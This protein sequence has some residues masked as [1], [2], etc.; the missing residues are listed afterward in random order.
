VH[1]GIQ[2][3]TSFNWPSNGFDDPTFGA[4]NYMYGTLLTSAIALLIGGFTSLG[5]AIFLAEYAPAWLR[6]PLSFLVELLAAVPSIV[7]GFWGVQFL[8]RLMG[9]GWGGARLTPC[10]RLAASLRRY[11]DDRQGHHLS[12]GL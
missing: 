10:L 11:R 3:F 4:L 5:A 9:G 8:S 7:Y 12:C 6:T 2:F 1:N